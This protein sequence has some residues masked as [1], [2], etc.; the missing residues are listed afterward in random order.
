MREKNSNNKKPQ[1]QQPR[2]RIDVV[3]MRRKLLLQRRQH[4]LQF[5]HRMKLEQMHVGMKISSF[6]EAVKGR[7][8]ECFHSKWQQKNNGEDKNPIMC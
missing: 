3:D 6:L 4:I 2:F 1:W 5:T 7:K 8:K